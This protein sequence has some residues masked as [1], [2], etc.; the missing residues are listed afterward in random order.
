[1]MKRENLILVGIILV[2]V[3]IF[4]S[5]AIIRHDHFN[6]QGWDLGFYEQIIWKYSRGQI[7]R[8]SISGNLDLADRFRP[9]MILFVIPYILRPQSSTLLISQTAA[10]ALTSFPLFYLAR[11]LTTNRLFSFTVIL[12]FLF[13][14]GTQS[15]QLNDFHEVALFPLAL[16]G[17]F[18][19]LE[20]KRYRA[21]S[22]TV[23]LT[24]MIRE[25]VGFLIA[26]IGL[27]MLLTHKPRKLSLITAGA[28]IAWSLIVIQFIMPKLGQTGYSGFLGDNASLVTELSKLIFHPFYTLSLFISPF[29][30]VKTILIS[31]ASFGFLPLFYPPL[32]IPVIVQFSQRFFDLVHP[33]RWTVYYQY[34]ADL[35]ALLA[36]GTILASKHLVNRVPAKNI[37]TYI[38][39]LLIA[40]VAIE[41]LLLPVPLK[42]LVKEEYFRSEAYIDNNQLLIKKIPQTASVATQNNLASHLSRRD[43]LYILP[44]IKKAEYI[45]MDL[46]SG[47]SKYNF[48]GETPEKMTD[49]M[50]KL[51]TNN[52]YILLAQKG[53]A[54]L[55]RKQIAD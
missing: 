28:G 8:S 47:Q 24:L 43:Q 53:D 51:L 35:A 50:N 38:T 20:S 9:L 4:S 3:F 6:S 44:E 1:M 11:N 29:T 36:I 54:Y 26:A 5:L 48:M 23:L 33:Y 21:F 55:L 2:Y 10:I 31:L 46:H 13:F 37:Y 39:L 22:I 52:R 17:L 32:L 12:A 16:A 40:S 18:Y 49:L 30:K 25:Y 7:A 27:Y 19:F 15:L 45:L 14:V 41:Q 42:L 34:S